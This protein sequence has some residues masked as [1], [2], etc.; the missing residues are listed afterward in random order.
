MKLT[1]EDLIKIIKEE[2][3]NL[4][5][6]TRSRTTTTTTS[7][8]FKYGDL[9]AEEKRDFDA[10]VDRR[11]QEYV[12]KRKGKVPPHRAKTIVKAKVTRDWI[13]GRK[14]GSSNVKTKTTTSRGTNQ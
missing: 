9:S 6:Q 14:P 3:N 11:T 1:K 12:N 10:E 13:Q 2:L 4:L 8:Q 5:E 7:G